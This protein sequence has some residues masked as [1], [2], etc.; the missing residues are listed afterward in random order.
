MPKITETATI[1]LDTET[2]WNEIGGFGSVG[3]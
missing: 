2:L 1:G 3:E